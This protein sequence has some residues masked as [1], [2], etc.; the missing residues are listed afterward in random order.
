MFHGLV[1]EVDG[2]FKTSSIYLD[3]LIMWNLFT[4]INIG[5]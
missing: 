2:L 4:C 5:I 1:N 3:K